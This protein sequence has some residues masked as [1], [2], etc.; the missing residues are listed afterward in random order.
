MLEGLGG[1]KSRPA[2][3]LHCLGT[4]SKQEEDVRAAFPDPR[5]HRTP[6]RRPW[7]AKHGS[8]YCWGRGYSVGASWGMLPTAEQLTRVKANSPLSGGVGQGGGGSLAE[9][10]PPGLSFPLAKSSQ[11]DWGGGC[12][13]CFGSQHAGDLVPRALVQG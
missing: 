5:F 9:P 13:G 4:G 12:P 6:H 10:T 11:L 7:P 3:P 8:V 2:C 1:Q